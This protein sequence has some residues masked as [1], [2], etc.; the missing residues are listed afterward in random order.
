M[1]TCSRRSFALRF[2]FDETFCVD[3]DLA[4]IRQGLGDA[5][6]ESAV[7]QASS[8]A[9]DPRRVNAAMLVKEPQGNVGFRRQSADDKLTP[10][11]ANTNVGVL[12]DKQERLFPR[13][14]E[15]AGGIAAK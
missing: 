6:G 4:E 3:Y 14:P 13:V 10:S 2:R 5:D 9:N 15:T 12:E 11:I 7:L 1:S 8:L